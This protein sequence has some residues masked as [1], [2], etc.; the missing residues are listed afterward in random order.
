MHVRKTR[1]SGA[2]PLV[3]QNIAGLPAVEQ[4]GQAADPTHIMTIP[5]RLR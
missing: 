5:A 1:G 2:S 3:R 4:A